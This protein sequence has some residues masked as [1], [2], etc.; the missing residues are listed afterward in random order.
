MYV[1]TEKKRKSPPNKGLPSPRRKWDYVEVLK[2]Y[3]VHCNVI[4]TAQSL[5]C[6][7]GVVVAAMAWRRALPPGEWRK[8]L[9][10]EL[11]Y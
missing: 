5:G 4:K 2:A 11:T 8:Y 10:G 7:N 9:S 6:T 3:D 1:S